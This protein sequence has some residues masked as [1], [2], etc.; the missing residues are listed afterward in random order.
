MDDRETS[1]DPIEVAFWQFNRENP[2]VYDALKRLAYNLISRGH[3]HYGIKALCEVVRF[4][5]V[6]ATHD[7]AFKINNNYT[8]LYA[9]L[10]MTS[11]PGLKGFFELRER[12][13]RRSV[14]AFDERVDA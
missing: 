2:Q 13:S 3:D 14:R 7:P 9:R 8:A 12:I 11:E 6:M 5:H 1:A 4:E 10:L